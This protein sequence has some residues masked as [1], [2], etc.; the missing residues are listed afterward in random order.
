MTVEDLLAFIDD[1]T[2]VIIRDVSPDQTEAPGPDGDGIIFTGTCNHLRHYK[3]DICAMKVTNI[4]PQA[5]DDNMCLLYITTIQSKITFECRHCNSKFITI[6]DGQ[7][8]TCMCPKC[9]H[10]MEIEDE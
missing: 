2:K 8:L 6:D 7:M 1:N 10:E 5:D 3:P 9:G 4:L